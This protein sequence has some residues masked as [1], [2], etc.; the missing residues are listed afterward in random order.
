MKEFFIFFE[1]IIEMYISVPLSANILRT[2]E[3]PNLTYRLGG[4]TPSLPHYIYSTKKNNAAKIRVWQHYFL[5][6]YNKPML[7]FGEII[8]KLK[9]IIL[10]YSRFQCQD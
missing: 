3:T 1:K 2:T 9:V 5:E 10:T 8:R 4:V 7:S 6:L